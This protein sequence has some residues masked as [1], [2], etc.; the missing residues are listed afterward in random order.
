M[1]EFKKGVKSWEGGNKYFNDP[2]VP[3][4]KLFNDPRKRAPGAGADSKIAHHQLLGE[5][6]VLAPNADSGDEKAAKK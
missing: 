4:G 3:C 1:G 2:A 5:S 6:D